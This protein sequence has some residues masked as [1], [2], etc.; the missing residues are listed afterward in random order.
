VVI[1][2]GSSG[3][4]TGRTSIPDRIMIFLLS[5]ESRPAL[6]PTRPPIQWIPG[7]CG[8]SVK[9]YTHLQLVPRSHVFMA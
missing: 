2:Y 7:K 6:D 4:V 8:R 9:L 5:T 3:I 1:S